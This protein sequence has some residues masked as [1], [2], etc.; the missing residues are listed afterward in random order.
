MQNDEFPKPMID[1]PNIIAVDFD[2]TCNHEYPK[3]GREIGA[4]PVLHELVKRG[5]KLILWTM[6]SDDRTDG[7]T[8]L[9][10]AVKWFET[11]GCRCGASSAIGARHLD[12]QPQGVCQALH[13]RCRLWRS[14][15]APA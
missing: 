10:D 2:G 8:P 15:C 14:V 12:Q 9:T 11:T 6:R 13:R 3:V 1:L 7:T 4:A 5:C